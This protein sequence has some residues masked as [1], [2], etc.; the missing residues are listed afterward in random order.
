MDS[1]SSRTVAAGVPAGA[2]SPYQDR[3]VEG[4]GSGIG[5]RRH[6]RKEPGATRSA[7]A[8]R[9]EPALSD[10]RQGDGD[11]RQRLVGPSSHGLVDR[12]GNRVRPACRDVHCFDENLEIELLNGHMRCGALVLNESLYAC[13][14]VLTSN[15]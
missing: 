11:R 3:K 14:L 6:R 12:V 2:Y 8:E 9:R 1:G 15:V 13:A 4:G 5:Q 7:D 10:V